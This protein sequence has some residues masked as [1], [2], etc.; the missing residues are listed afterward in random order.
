MLLERP[1]QDP[2]DDI[3]GRRALAQSIIRLASSVPRNQSIRIAI[4]GPW[5]SGKSTT[6][7]FIH[8]LARQQQIPVVFLDVW[9]AQSTAELWEAFIDAFFRGLDECGVKGKGKAWAKARKYLRKGATIAADLPLDDVVSKATEALL[10]GPV[11]LISHVLDVVRKSAGSALSKKLESYENLL[12]SIHQDNAGSEVF[13]LI[14]ELDRLPPSLVRELV[15]SLRMMLDFPG[16]VFV[17][18]FDEVLLSDALLTDLAPGVNAVAYL[19]KFIDVHRRIPELTEEARSAY[20]GRLIE[21][22]TTSFPPTILQALRKFLPGTPRRLKM[23]AN[24]LR[25]IDTELER[26]WPNEHE[27]PFELA[28]AALLKVYGRR[29]PAHLLTTLPNEFEIPKLF[30]K[31]KDERERDTTSRPS[32]EQLM[33]N[34]GLEKDPDRVQIERLLKHILR[35]GHLLST[36]LSSRL[37]LTERP[38]AITGKECLAIASE[39]KRAP[40]SL[41]QEASI[42]ATSVDGWVEFVQAAIN[43]WDLKASSALDTT[44]EIEQSPILDDS[45]AILDLL[46]QILDQQPERAIPRPLARRLISLIARAAPHSLNNSCADA[47]SHEAEFLEQTIR[48]HHIT[49]LEAYEALTDD[50]F[51]LF[52]SHNPPAFWDRLTA[53]AEAL[54][55]DAIE[56]AYFSHEAMDLDEAFTDGERRALLMRVFT[57][58]ASGPFWSQQARYQALLPSLDGLEFVTARKNCFELIKRLDYYDHGSSL[59]LNRPPEMLAELWRLAVLQPLQPRQTGDAIKLWERWKAVPG[60]RLPDWLETEMQRRQQQVDQASAPASLT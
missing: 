28:C 14:D 27:L 43:A 23:L 51:E 38:V 31:P 17:L 24:E 29:L 7:R 48:D 36:Q 12:R 25:A 16:A 39:F 30:Q 26:F 58:G 5:G 4:D 18:A 42:L 19:D 2:R 54:A 40:Q 45:N 56:Q 33:Q 52:G 13:V 15:H 55:A 41:P 35:S 44:F 34:A 10:P 9:R 8:A 57:Q 37:W 3:L 6:L 21:T 60:A 59:A 46:A 20:L 32:P 49:P 11:G 22:T 1:V 47:R 50:N 53:I